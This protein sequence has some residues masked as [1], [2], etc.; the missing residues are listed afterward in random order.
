MST[1]YGTFEEL[2]DGKTEIVREIAIELKKQ[3]LKLHPDST[4][5]VR[6]GDRA[7]SFGHG[8]K[9]MSEAYCYIMPLKERV[10]LGFYHGALLQDPNKIL[11]GTGK[12][13]RH[14]KIL[15]IKQAGSFDIV[16]LLSDAIAERKKTLEV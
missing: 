9:K 11:E 13:L 14:V 16:N 1:A 12:K 2:I 10:N 8:S 4:E 6:I 5:V 7:A 3:V 15:S